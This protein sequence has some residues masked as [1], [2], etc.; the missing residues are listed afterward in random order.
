VQREHT[1]LGEHLTHGRC[2]VPTSAIETHDEWRSIALEV[3]SHC[4]GGELRVI[5]RSQSDHSQR[6]FRSAGRS[7]YSSCTRESHFVN[8]SLTQ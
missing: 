6:V 3:R 1:V 8:Q 5:V 2:I 4:A 7:L